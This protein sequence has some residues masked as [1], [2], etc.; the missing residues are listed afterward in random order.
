MSNNKLMA[1][2][3]AIRNYEP[4]DESEK[5]D[6]GTMLQVLEQYKGKA[7]C[8]ECLIGHFTT[9]VFLFNKEHTKALMCYHLIDRTWTW[10]G[11]HA[12]G[13]ANLREVALREVSEEAGIS[14]K[15]IN[16]N[17]IAKLT[18]IPVK[19]HL[20]NGRWVPSHTHYD[21]AFVGEAD[22]NVK[23][24]SKP[25]ENS[26]VKWI[27]ISSL[28]SEVED[29]WKYDNLFDRMIERYK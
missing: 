11:G 25:D 2:E 18:C 29:K 8:R 7:L 10:L 6:K 1:L 5:I 27:P 22:E 23:I 14:C 20:K 9:S 26:G 12:D 13:I 15:L 16:G 21:L 28:S 17:K 4:Y 3:K 19:G 24:T